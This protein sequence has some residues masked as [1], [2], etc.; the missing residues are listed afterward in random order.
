MSDFYSVSSPPITHSVFKETFT[1]P[2]LPSPIFSPEKSGQS[3]IVASACK[4]GKNGERTSK[5]GSPD[6]LNR[7]Y[8]DDMS[9]LK[10]HVIA[11][12]NKILI[13]GIAARKFPAMDV[14]YSDGRKSKLPIVFDASGVDSSKL[15]V[16]EGSL[17]CLPFRANSQAMVDSWSKPFYDAF[18]ESKSV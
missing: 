7:G 12:A 11:L 16:P 18:S 10:Q 2:T 4:Q 15:A 13:P 1:L 6:E 3:F 5:T 17:V 9:E 8:F 14:I